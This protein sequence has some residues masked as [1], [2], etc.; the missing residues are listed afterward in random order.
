MQYYVVRMQVDNKINDSYITSYQQFNIKI[1]SYVGKN[2][3]FEERK[4]IHFSKNHNFRDNIS[5]FQEN[6]INLQQNQQK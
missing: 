6:Y 1:C 4:R 3:N 5:D 2:K